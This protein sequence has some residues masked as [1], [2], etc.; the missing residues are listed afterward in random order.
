[1]SLGADAGTVVRMLMATGL[2]PV[3]VGGVIGLALAFLLASGLSGLLFGIGALDPLTFVA[4]PLVLGAVAALA[5][6]VP[7]RRVSRVDP[8]SALRSE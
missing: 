7:A 3:I 8:V 1:M 6:Y 4:V 2:R 5:T